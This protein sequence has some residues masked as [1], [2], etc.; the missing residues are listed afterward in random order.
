MDTIELTKEEELYVNILGDFYIDLSEEFEVRKAKLNAGRLLVT[1][2]LKREAIPQCRIDFIK[3]PIH[4]LSNSPKSKEQIFED[5]GTKG[6]MIFKDGNFLK[7]LKYFLYGPDLPMSL[8]SQLKGV[9]KGH[10]YS[11]E[12]VENAKPIIRTFFKQSNI[13]QKG[14]ATEIYKL[15]LELGIGQVYSKQLRDS[16]MKFK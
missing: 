15:C 11:D 4:N 6:E 2:L 9:C 8:I 5:N 7:Y 10:Y 13:S 14:I 1:S 12:F 16:V 3:K